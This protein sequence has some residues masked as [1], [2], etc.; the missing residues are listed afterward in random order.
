MLSPE[1]ESPVNGLPASL[2]RD[3]PRPLS[4]VRCESSEPPRVRLAGELMGRVEVSLGF[5]K[6][7][8]KD[9]FVCGQE[10]VQ[11]DNKQLTQTVSDEI[12]SLANGIGKEVKP[13]RLEVVVD[14]D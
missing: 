2:S 1:V 11:R 3:A 13:Q 6:F 12:G 4:A 9:A 8:L 14:N 5:L 10:G 7:D